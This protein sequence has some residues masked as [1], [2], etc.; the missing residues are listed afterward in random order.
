M[1]KREWKILII[2]AVALLVITA[3]YPILTSLRGNA[4][5]ETG[6]SGADN[7]Q[8]LYFHRTQ[9][10]VSCN[11]AEAYARETLD[12]YFAPEL[13]SGKLSIQS[14]DYQT[15][16]AMAEKYNVKMQ[17]L[18]LLITRGG[19]QTVKD[20]PEVWAL[21]RDKEACIG[22]LRDTLNKELGK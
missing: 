10:C 20:V 5:A 3:C 21:V 7:I 13:S 22:C 1:V 19:Q 12:R 2:I 11:N 18:K 16:K 15:D 4:G 9:R 14:I 8:L 17:G 6:S